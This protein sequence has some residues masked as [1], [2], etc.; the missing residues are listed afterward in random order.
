MP[1]PMQLVKS[2][3]LY[4]GAS[5]PATWPNMAF[6]QVVLNSTSFCALVEVAPIAVKSPARRR[7][8]AYLAA[9]GS[10]S[11]ARAAFGFVAG[12]NVIRGGPTAG[13]TSCSR[14]MRS[15]TARPCAKGRR[16]SPIGRSGLVPPISIGAGVCPGPL[17]GRWR[18]PGYSGSPCRRKWAAPGATH[19]GYATLMEELSHGRAS[20]ASEYGMP[21]GGGPGRRHVC[22]W[23]PA[24]C[25]RSGG[26]RRWR[27]PPA[28][29]LAIKGSRVGTKLAPKR[30]P[31]SLI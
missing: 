26:P 8:N 16:A 28:V 22:H 5:A 21:G 3:A 18:R 25:G 7:L 1:R 30:P 4:C 24:S 12:A 10:A 29:H 27:H 17:A 19:G 23:R 2:C 15:R 9:C 11:L 14:S 6:P 31:D 13:R 20:V